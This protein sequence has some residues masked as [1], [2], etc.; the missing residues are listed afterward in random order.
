[1]MLTKIVV[2]VFVLI[3]VFYALLLIPIKRNG[4]LPTTD[5][6]LLIFNHPLP[7]V[8]VVVADKFVRCQT[9][10]NPTYIL[11][12]YPESILHTL[13]TFPM[14]KSTMT[15]PVHWKSGTTEKLSQKIGNG[16]NI[17]AFYASC[18]KMH[19]LF[20]AMLSTNV[21][22]YT[23]RI[24]KNIFHVERVEYN[25]DMSVAQIRAIVRRQLGY[26]P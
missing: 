17:A 16:N 22:T 8:D 7:Y 21:S 26:S 20:W 11:V 2:G 3:L 4:R 1:M 13:F 23:I 18:S 25:R 12:K 6:C 5:P 9:F 14:S 15:M 24:Q 10:K 19:G